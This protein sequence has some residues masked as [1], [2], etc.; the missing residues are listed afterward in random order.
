MRYLRVTLRKF[1]I[2][3][4]IILKIRIIKLNQWMYEILSSKKELK[5]IPQCPKRLKKVNNSQL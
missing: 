5:M 1:K 3:R 4:L 2:I